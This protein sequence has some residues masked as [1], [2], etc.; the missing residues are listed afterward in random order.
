MVSL[1]LFMRDHGDRPVFLFLCFTFLSMMLCIQ[2]SNCWK[3]PLIGT[4]SAQIYIIYMWHIWSRN[5][6]PFEI[7]WVTPVFG[8]AR[9]SFLVFCVVL[10]FFPIFLLL[11]LVFPILAVSLD[12]PFLIDPLVFSNL[13]PVFCVPNIGSVSGLSILDCPFDFL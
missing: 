11:C 7:T 1:P 12:C 13:R 9:S 6:L 5:C 10:C 4:R 2:L 3:S 8:V